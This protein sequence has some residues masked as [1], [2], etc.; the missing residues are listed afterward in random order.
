MLREA[1]PRSRR[2]MNIAE[3]LEVTRI[4][5]VRG[6]LPSDVPSCA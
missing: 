5:S 3:A 2:Q 4:F 6:L 1:M